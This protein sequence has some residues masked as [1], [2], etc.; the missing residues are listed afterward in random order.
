M[1]LHYLCKWKLKKE[2]EARKSS[3]PLMGKIKDK[4]QIK[5]G[6][7]RLSVL[8]LLATESELVKE[9]H[10][11]DLVDESVRRKARKKLAT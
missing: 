10:F 3:F 7:R 11:D 2:K 6:Q 9:L 1:N 5:M 4:L 8:S